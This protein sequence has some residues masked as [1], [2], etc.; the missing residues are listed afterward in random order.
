MTK[1]IK[2][3][4]I[5]NGG[6]GKRVKKLIKNRP[7]CLIKFYEHS[8]L[9]LQ[10]KLLKKKGFNKFLILTKKNNKSLKKEINKF[11]SKNIKIQIHS[12]KSKLGTGGAI[13]NAFS[14]LDEN[15]SL[16]YGDSWLD[17]NLKKINHRFYKSKKNSLITVIS[18]KIVDHKPNMLIKKNK[19]LNYSKKNYKK[20][21]FVDY[22][23]QIFNKQ[24]FK[25][26]DKKVFDLNL[27]V[28]ELIKKNDIEIEFIKKRFYE[29]GSLKGVK[30]FKKYLM[31]LKLNGKKLV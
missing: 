4:V 10:L 8:F 1:K 24:I 14:K 25:N 5:L 11:N 30:E 29:I 21:N 2:Q 6:D 27:I 18:K 26:I 17:F 28:R 12:E 23:Y 15:F 7:K 13:K 9:S 19:V 22:G 3:I 31:D 20:N 16:I